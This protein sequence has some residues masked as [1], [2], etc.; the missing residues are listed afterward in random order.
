MSRTCGF[1]FWVEEGSTPSA[2]DVIIDTII[3]DSKKYGA[4]GYPKPSYDYLDNGE[5]EFMRYGS[6]PIV[7]TEP[8]KE[9]DWYYE[10]AM[11][12]LT[13][14]DFTNLRLKVGVSYAACTFT[15]GSKR[16]SYN[17]EL[18]C[19]IIE[20]LDGVDLSG[21]YLMFYTERG[22]YVKSKPNM[23]KLWKGVWL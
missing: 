2:I 8:I 22:E 20:A 7:F 5:P 11:S 23:S 12:D 18:W 10:G 6:G 3:E 21:V 1:T 13:K 16:Y 9:V 15:V 19:K 4:H 14:R 17:Y